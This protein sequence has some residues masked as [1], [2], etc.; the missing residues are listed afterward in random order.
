ML[1]QSFFPNFGQGPFPKTAGKGPVQVSL[2]ADAYCCM[3]D[4]VSSEN[5]A[6]IIP[7]FCEMSLFKAREWWSTTVGEDEDFDQGCLC[8]A[9]IDNSDDELGKNSGIQTNLFFARS[10]LGPSPKLRGPGFC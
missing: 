7:G 10:M 5:T 3:E 9:N 8:L 1:S 6:L 4:I 2:L